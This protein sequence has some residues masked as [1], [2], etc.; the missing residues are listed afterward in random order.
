VALG[1]RGRAVKLLFSFVGGRGHF[2]PL[3]PLANAATAQ[4]HDVRVAGRPSMEAAVVDAGH[5]FVAVQPDVVAPAEIVP[6]AE[7][8]P[9]RERLVLRHGF[10]GR[11][12]RLRATDV[13][14]V[15]EQERPDIIIADEIDFGAL[16][17]AEVL[18]I[19]RVVV[20]VS[21]A[22]DFV[23]PEVVAEPLA[24][25]RAAFGLTDD[26]LAMTIGDAVVAPVP[27]MFRDPGRPL[28]ATTKWMR[29]AV[30]D[31]VS[32]PSIWPTAKELPRVHVT[33]GTIFN[34]ESGDLFA[35]LL[36]AVA[37][38]DADV[39]VTVGN[40]I[41][42]STFGAPP[43]HVRIE[44]FLAPTSVFPGT[45]LVIS[46]GGSGT[47]VS[48]LACGVPQLLVPMG[49]DQPDNARRCEALGIG[50]ALD[51]VRATPSEIGAEAARLLNDDRCRARA[52]ALA[53]EAARLPTAAE[54]L[55]DLV[56]LAD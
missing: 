26:G 27:P 39:V 25:V 36:D 56:A 45:D 41:D 31:T 21:A 12:A 6:L 22:G 11:T 47:V 54:V 24:A 14:V 10:A 17:A 42:P 1:A 8:D 19:P 34:M 29:P 44:R 37:G 20:M 50:V 4:G 16:I 7:P 52:L 38:L 2:D 23:R 28:P 43:P 30:L 3:L 32:S 55:P 15:C 53:D 49:A 35:R 46:H 5:R 9:D 40:D 51:P 13:L 18:G 33:L 48:A